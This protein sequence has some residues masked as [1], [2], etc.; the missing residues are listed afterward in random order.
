MRVT[1]RQM[2]GEAYK[3]KCCRSQ[4]F[5]SDVTCNT[6]WVFALEVLSVHSFS[7]HQ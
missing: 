2:E 4:F 7:G 3:I 1:W 5:C 6:C